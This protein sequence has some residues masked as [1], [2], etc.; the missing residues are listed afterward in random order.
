MKRFRFVAVVTLLSIISFHYCKLVYGTPEVFKIQP[1]LKYKV[2]RIVPIENIYLIYAKNI[3]GKLFKIISKK[4]EA[5]SC[6]D[7]RVG[8]TYRLDLSGRLFDPY[9]EKG[10]NLPLPA[11]TSFLFYGVQVELEG[12][13]IQTL[14]SVDNVKGLCLIK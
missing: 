1:L 5:D 9:G 14:Y 3:A 10:D 6:N 2:Q 13:S 4:E 11:P 12:D 8:G 7:I